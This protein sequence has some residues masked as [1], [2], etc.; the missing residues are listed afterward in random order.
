[1]ILGIFAL[2]LAVTVHEFCHAVTAVFLGDPTPRI[3][4]RVSLNPMR[5]LDPLGSIVVPLVLYIS[6]APVFGWAK[7]VLFNP[8]NL[9]KPTRD[10]ALIGLAGPASNLLMAIVTAIPLKYL[11]ATAFANTV[12]F[13][14]IGVFFIVN[15]SLFSLNILPFPPFDGSKIIGLFI[16]YRFRRQYDVFL[17]KGVL[18]V[19]VFIAFDQMI[20][21]WLIGFSIINYVL[22]QIG[23]F[24]LL[25][26][27]LG[28]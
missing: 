19:L 12:F 8:N 26:V 15:I 21:S 10:S 3:H 18:W 24:L 17:E 20:L 22:N 23:T 16:P 2:V 7:P 9:R 27:G 6:H 1:M 25:L 4:G 5:H 28:T 11:A 13:E 14:F